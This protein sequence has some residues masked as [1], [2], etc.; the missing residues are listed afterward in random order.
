M[1]GR[2]KE[3]SLPRPMTVV[4][5]T[6]S[7]LRGG[8]PFCCMTKLP[9]LTPRCSQYGLHDKDMDSLIRPERPLLE[10]TIHRN[11]RL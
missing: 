11:N 8:F 3:Q 10:G 1:S 5:R 4:C 9:K 6:S 2:I 7:K